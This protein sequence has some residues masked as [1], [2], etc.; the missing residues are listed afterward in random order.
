MATAELALASARNPTTPARGAPPPNTLS[1]IGRDIGRQ[2]VFSGGFG[3]ARFH[4]VSSRASTAAH[5]G[6]SRHASPRSR[7]SATSPRACR[8]SQ[9]RRV[10]VSATPPFRLPEV[11]HRHLFPQ[12]PTPVLGERDRRERHAG[13]SAP[14]KF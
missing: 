5:L 6:S 2:P 4:G 11:F 13:A 3:V 14:D 7:P 1:H 9:A 12:L 8:S 10:G